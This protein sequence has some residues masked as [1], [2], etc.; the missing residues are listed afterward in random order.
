M[1]AVLISVALSFVG[2]THSWSICNNCLVTVCEY[3]VDPK[4]NYY[5]SWYPTVLHVPYGS[6]C[7]AFVKQKIYRPKKK[8]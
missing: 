7:P 5:K 8:R 1:E 3:R 2:A 6:R 4:V